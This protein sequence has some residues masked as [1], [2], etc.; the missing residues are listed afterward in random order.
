[1]STI[2]AIE[3]TVFRLPLRGTLR[4][5]TS[6][7]LA[8]L[9][10][11]LVRLRDSEG[12]EGIAEA[13][14]R[15]TIYG[16]TAT[17]IVAIIR[18]ELAPRLVGLPLADVA[19]LNR[20]MAE[21]AGNPTA[22]GAIDMAAHDALA[23]RAGQPL[24][25]FLGATQPRARVS[26]IL[27]LADTSTALREA[28][29]VYDQGVRVLKVKVGNEWAADIARVEA[30]RAEF[31]GSDLALYA[32][33]NECWPVAE[34]A[35]RLRGLAERG[36]LFCEEPLPVELLRERAALRSAA[37]LPLIA[38]DSAFTLR[39]LRREI[40]FDTFDILNI[41]TPRTG[42]SQSAEMLRLA[43]AHGKQVMVG[44]QAGSALGTA[45]AAAFA[46]LPGIT[47]PS[48][49]SFHLKVAA[50]IAPPI[51]LRDGWLTIA[52]LDSVRLDEGA[53]AH[54]RVD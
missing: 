41:K 2:A 48:E 50:D 31:A 37:I 23:Q 40:A 8:E 4:W 30:L 15:P 54:C 46:A 42:Y 29:E 10:H 7:R 5:G 24:A 52:D 16:E 43:L 22:K 3:T 47:A 27:G 53:L 34:A 21:I 44:S 38:D 49:L 13:P 9:E 11:V 18:D 28:R 39:D 36:L 25:A 32:D 26:Y 35:T 1:M 12:V 14:P 20:R 19:A 6:G 51:P 33:A 45:R 17:S